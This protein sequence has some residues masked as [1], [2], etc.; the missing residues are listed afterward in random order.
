MSNRTT[1]RGVPWRTQLVCRILGA[2]RTPIE[3][4]SIAD[5][6]AKRDKVFPTAPP[7]SWITG[8]VPSGVSITDATITARDGHAVPVRRYRPDDREG[9]PVVIYF[10][11]GGWVQGNT[12]MYDPLC[13]RIAHE[14]E[15]VVVS[16]DYRLAPEHPAPVPVQDCLDATT[17]L[18]ADPGPGARRGPVALAGDSAGGNIAAILAQQLRDEATPDGVPAIAHQVLIY[19]ATDLTM[20][21]PSIDEHPN[22]PILTKVGMLAFRDLY[23]GADQSHERLTDPMLSPLFG[24]LE[25]VAPALILTGELDPIRDDGLRYAAALRGSGVS[26]RSTTYRGLPHGFVSMVGA[27]PGGRQIMAEIVDELRTHLHGTSPVQ[28]SASAQGLSSVDGSPSTQGWG[29]AQGVGD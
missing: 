9:L 4:S 29:S 28:T 11:G 13:A 18:L 21:S 5:I 15:V 20:S 25:E 2:T 19:P 10:H 12:R 1:Y 26:V 23:V 14:A 24:D 27:C 22:A 6:Q 8:A 16:V 17:A 7:V 3:T